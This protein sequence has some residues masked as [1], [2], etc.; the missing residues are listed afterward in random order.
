MTHDG[1]EEFFSWMGSSR[2]KD[3]AWA[4][5]ESPAAAAEE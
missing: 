4:K 2:V 3:F 1:E 5:E